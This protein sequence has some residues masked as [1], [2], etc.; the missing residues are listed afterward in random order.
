MFVAS[1]YNRDYGSF[2]HI[3][4]FKNCPPGKVDTFIF[5]VAA[6]PES[7]RENFQLKDSKFL[8]QK[9]SKQTPRLLTL[10]HSKAAAKLHTSMSAAHNAVCVLNTYQSLSIIDYDPVSLVFSIKLPCVKTQSAVF[11]LQWLALL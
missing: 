1:V 5:K 9:F 6:G 4:E 7:V 3:S 2:W 11:T 8:E 10:L